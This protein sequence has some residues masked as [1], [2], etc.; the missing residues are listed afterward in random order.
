MI[1]WKDLEVFMSDM[2]EQQKEQRVVLINFISERMDTVEAVELIEETIHY[3]NAGTLWRERQLEN[4]SESDFMEFIKHIDD[5][6]YEGEM[7]LIVD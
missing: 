4:Y 1:T 3:H 6:V 5:S 2:T 7:A